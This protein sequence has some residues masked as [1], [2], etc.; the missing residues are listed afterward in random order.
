MSMRIPEIEAVLIL[1][2][3]KRL[4]T[5]DLASALL[6]AFEVLDNP[7][8]PD[9]PPYYLKEARAASRSLR[10]ALGMH[11]YSLVENKFSPDRENDML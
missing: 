6:A 5:G 2:Q 11:D 1:M 3:E 8:A 10:L 9:N 4:C 7:I